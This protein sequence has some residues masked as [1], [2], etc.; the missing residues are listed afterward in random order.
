MCIL[1][2]QINQELVWGPF[3]RPVWEIYYL[4]QVKERKNSQELKIKKCP[5]A[6]NQ[7]HPI[8]TKEYD[9]RFNAIFLYLTQYFFELGGIKKWLLQELK[10]KS[11]LVLTKGLNPDLTLWCVW[12][13]NHITCFCVDRIKTQTLNYV[14]QSMAFVWGVSSSSKRWPTQDLPAEMETCRKGILY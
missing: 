14:F 7:L 3:K 4:K 11:L 2:Q 5:V 6:V 10:N 12:G 13:W 9:Q 8:K 1:Y